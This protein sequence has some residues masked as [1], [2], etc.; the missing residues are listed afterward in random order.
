MIRWYK[1]LDN[2][3][4]ILAGIYLL[5]VLTIVIPPIA[6]APPRDLTDILAILSGIIVFILAL[7]FGVMD[8]PSDGAEIVWLQVVTAIALIGFPIWAVF[9]RSRLVL[10]ACYIGFM[11]AVLLTAHGCSSH[12]FDALP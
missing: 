1:W 2:P 8:I 6:Q 7:P 5:G 4:R 9:T 10:L 12:H 3:A 11:L